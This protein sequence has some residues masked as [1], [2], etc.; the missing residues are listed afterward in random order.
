MHGS[1]VDGAVARLHGSFL[2]AVELE[3]E[4]TLDDAAVADGE[5]AVGVGL[6]AGGEVDDADQ[7]A[8]FFH[9]AGLQGVSRE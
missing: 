4:F 9:Q 1:A 6:H 5:G 8:V 3:L 2:A 7:G